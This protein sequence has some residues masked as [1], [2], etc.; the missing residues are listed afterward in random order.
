APN[1]PLPLCVLHLH[2][3]LHG[4]RADAAPYQ[5]PPI[6]GGVWARSSHRAWCSN[7]VCVNTRLRGPVYVHHGQ[8]SAWGGSCVG[9]VPARSSGVTARDP[10]QRSPAGP[11]TRAAPPLLPRLRAGPPSAAPRGSAPRARHGWW[12]WRAEFL[13]I[14]AWVLLPGG[15]FAYATSIPPPAF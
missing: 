10:A 1:C 3:C 2:K 12:P 15:H 11:P 13:V 9:G 4:R 6:A 14:L 5:T 8:V 7:S